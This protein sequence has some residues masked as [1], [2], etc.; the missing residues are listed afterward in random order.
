[1]CNCMCMY[2]CNCMCIM[3]V[4]EHVCVYVCNYKWHLTLN[5]GSYSM[6]SCF[7]NTFTKKYY[8][9]TFNIKVIT[10]SSI[11]RSCFKYHLL[12]MDLHKKSIVGPYI[13]KFILTEQAYSYVQPFTF[14]NSFFNYRLGV[15]S[16]FLIHT[17]L[18]SFTSQGLYLCTIDIS[19]F[20]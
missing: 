3:Y 16:P 11:A 5:S 20:E 12:F 17:S 19:W 15:R 1:M 9:S 6:A 2:V 13:Q 7:K 18:V 14:Q 4:Y 8:R 10:K